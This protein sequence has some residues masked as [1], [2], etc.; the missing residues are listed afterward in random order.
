MQE[1]GRGPF[2]SVAGL[3][4]RR[5]LRGGRMEPDRKARELDFL[6]VGSCNEFSPTQNEN[7]SFCL[8]M[9]LS[10]LNYRICKKCSV[11]V[12]ISLLSS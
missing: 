6:G 7:D 8:K 11:N 9:L 10:F 2:L 1:P 4:L 5:V 3:Q 12:I